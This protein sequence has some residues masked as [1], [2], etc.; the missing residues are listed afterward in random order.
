MRRFFLSLLAAE[1]PSFLSK[2]SDHDVDLA[3]NISRLKEMQQA[4]TG[5]NPTAACAIYDGLPQSLKGDK[6]MLLL[7]LRAAQELGDEAYRQALE[8]FQKY[9]PDDPSLDLVSIDH[10]FLTKQYD[11]ELAVIDHI[12]STIGGD[13]YLNI[14][15]ANTMLV[16]GKYNEALRYAK[17]A[18]DGDKQMQS[19][20]ETELGIALKA[21]NYSD[22]A[23]V[24]AILDRDFHQPVD[25]LVNDAQF[26]G[27]RKSKEYLE[28]KK[29]TNKDS[30]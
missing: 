20:Y 8:D 7:R 2:A 24:L 16:Q 5:G 28:W 3:K 15:R 11:K 22:V 23:R 30:R 10:Y 18:S 17:K 29:T 13:P 25:S 12:E 9:H 14:Y 1:K 19:A 21:K 4:A 26:A 6:Y 27:F